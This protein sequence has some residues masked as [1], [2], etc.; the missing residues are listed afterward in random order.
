M[1]AEST[2][3]A[4]ARYDAFISYS[5]RDAAF[6]RRLEKALESYVP[7]KEL[8][9]PHRRL[10]IFR[11]EEDITGTDYFRAI[12][13]HLASSWRLVVL[14][15][16][17]SRGSD[18]VNDEIRRFVEARDPG[19][20]ISILVDGVPNNEATASEEADKAFPQALCE[21]QEMPLA[22][23][24]REL[25]PARQRPD[26]A[27]FEA[28]WYRLLA[29]I[30]GISRAE[31]EQRDRKLRLRRRRRRTVTAAVLAAVLLTAGVVSWRM[32]LAKI[33][34]DRA[35][36][37]E[38]ALKQVTSGQQARDEGRELLARHL[39]G[40]AIAVAPAEMKVAAFV[41]EANALRYDVILRHVWQQPANAPSPVATA[42][43]GRVLIWLDENG[44]AQIRDGVTGE[45]V[46]P[47]LQ[48]LKNAIWMKKYRRF[49]AW[50]EDSRVRFLADDGE[51]IGTRIPHA[52]VDERPVLSSDEGLVVTWTRQDAVMIWDAA[53]GVPFG[54]ELAHDGAVREAIL[55][56]RDE[57]LI[58]IS[59]AADG[60]S[61]R[62]VRWWDTENGEPRG[63]PM[64]HGERVVEVRPAEDGSAV[65]TQDADDE[66]RLWDDTGT[67]RLHRLPAE[68]EVVDDAAL[69]R[70]GR[71]LLIRGRDDDEDSEDVATS[72]WDVATDERI[73]DRERRE[74]YEA[75]IRA[76][77]VGRPRVE[78]RFN[79]FDRKRGIRV[80]WPDGGEIKE[81]D[82]GLPKRDRPR[83]ADVTRSWM[84]LAEPDSARLYELSSKKQI[85]PAAY[86]AQLRGAALASDGRRF[87]TWGGDG[88]ARLWQVLDSPQIGSRYSLRGSW[89]GAR[90][91]SDGRSVLAWGDGLHRVE[92]E[93]GRATELLADE[94]ISGALLSPDHELLL[95][96]WDRELRIWQAGTA[97]L[98]HSLDHQHPIEE[99]LLSPDGATVLTLADTAY[100]WDAETAQPIAVGFDRDVRGATFGA[101][102]RRLLTWDGSETARLWD[103][104][105]WQAISPPLLHDEPV[106]GARFSRNG[107]SLTTWSRSEVYLWRNGSAPPARFSHGFGLHG[108]ELSPDGEL[109]LSWGEGKRVRVWTV[110]TGTPA[111]P[112]LEHED[113]VSSAIFSPE[114]DSILTWS[115]LRGWLW[116]WSRRDGGM[117][118]RGVDVGPDLREGGDLS[119]LGSV[120]AWDGDG[121]LMLA[122]LPGDLDFPR[123]H[124][125]TE[126]R[127]L[128]GSKLDEAGEVA[129][130][131]AEE[132]AATRA[133]YLEVSREHAPHCRYRAQNVYLRFFAP[134][135]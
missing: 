118:G 30:Y 108:A 26:R 68:G 37:R 73:R 12:E 50:G 4:E 78:W 45:T 17:R 31:I 126:V 81:L 33:D 2:S 115:R 1:R 32:R 56:R 102:P 96:W 107:R 109:L 61:R 47:E 116:A 41:Q 5:R 131:S 86:H 122:S 42:D 18:F 34:S 55:T 112:D 110:A 101:D 43:L 71:M 77:S 128:S 87:L 106:A 60:S 125:A 100:L 94:R 70:D 127:A 36:L 74:L 90:F 114:G 121:Y 52:V 93:T 79:S 46:G 134:P 129:P 91:A 23:D 15:S 69:T 66:V 64:E 99:V 65:V 111:T 29:E 72:L 82:L 103:P 27:P 120:V 13:E 97:K 76:L 35:A 104:S 92:P 62:V 132:L 7:P 75:E 20:V 25:D 8:D 63:S 119:P 49:M 51:E 123:E 28:V 105:T 22:I 11:D 84:L 117:I 38:Q 19:S 39:F 98:L 124:H 40:Q 83:L 67:L 95:T 58:T 3:R 130:L 85:G 89:N 57:L 48:G 9:V 80:L 24:Y 135:S 14:C 44:T 53:E 88:T 21:H 113:A 6:A 16:P 10:R 59:D 133:T 54:P